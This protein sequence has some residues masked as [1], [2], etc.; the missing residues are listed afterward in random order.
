[1]ETPLLLGL[2]AAAALNAAIPGPGLLLVVAR[3]ARSGLRAGIDTAIGELVAVSMLLAVVIAVMLGALHL[4]DAAFTALQFCGICLL[5]FLGLH[6]LRAKP[7]AGGSAAVPSRKG[8]LLAGFAVAAMSPFNLLFFLALLPQFVGRSDLA[9]QSLSLVVGLVLLGSAIPLAAAAV[10]SAGQTR[11]A[12]G[13]AVWMVRAS[14]ATFLGLA[15][16]SVVA[17]A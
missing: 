5:V 16:L 6:M 17:L 14:G 3:T 4:G 9:G 2:F 8:D 1:M 13:G 15:V 10:L 7:A 12:P 11:M